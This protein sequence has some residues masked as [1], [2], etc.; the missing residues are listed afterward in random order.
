MK[1]KLPPRFSP[2][3]LAPSAAPVKKAIKQERPRGSAHQRGYDHAWNKL[4]IAFRKRHPFC[5]WCAQQ[6]RDSLTALVDHM[7]PVVDRPDLRLNWKNLLPLCEPCHGRKFPMEVYARENGLLDDL[8]T[9][10]LE[11]KSRPRQFRPIIE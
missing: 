8:P 3:V 5:L 1:R 10:C 4:S 6:G 11:P 9:W 7:I 2:A